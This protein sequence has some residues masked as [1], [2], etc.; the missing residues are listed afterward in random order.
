MGIEE[1]PHIGGYLGLEI[2]GI[3][4]APGSVWE[5]WTNGAEAACFRNGRSALAWLLRALDC[6]RVWLP[7]YTCGVVTAG[8]RGAGAQVLYYP[9]GGSLQPSPAFLAKARPG[10]AVVVNCYFGRPVCPELADAVRGRPDLIRVEDRAQAS[11]AAPPVGDWMLYSPRKTL[12]VSDGGIIAR[13]CPA[14]SSTPLRRP[15]GGRRRPAARAH[16]TAPGRS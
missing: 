6:S 7:G 2:D 11:A 12:G 14:S 5:L 16:I 13:G 10:D 4:V 9:A 1:A 3:P 15:G 8:V